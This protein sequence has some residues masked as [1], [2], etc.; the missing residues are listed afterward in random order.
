MRSLES[1]VNQVLLSDWGRRSYKEH[2]LQHQQVDEKGP[3]VPR[4]MEVRRQLRLGAIRRFR[5]ESTDLKDPYWPA[6]AFPTRPLR[7]D[8]IGLVAPAV[9]SDPT[10]FR[11]VIRF[12]R[13]AEVVAKG[14][15]GYLP[16]DEQ[17]PTVRFIAPGRPRGRLRFAVTSW[18]TSDAQW[19]AAASGK[20]DRSVTRYVAFNGMINRI[21]KEQNRPDY[22]VMSELS[23]PLRWALRAARKLAD[24]GV[25]ML[26]GIE[27]HRD[28]STGKLRNDCLVSLTT[29][30]PGYAS[31][32]VVLQPKFE[33]AHGERKQ[34][35]KLLGKAGTLYK[36]RCEKAKPTIYGHRGFYFSLLICSDLTNI[37]HRNSLRGEIDALFVLEWNQ[38]IKTFAALVESTANDLHAFIVQANNRKFGDSRIRAPAIQDYARDMVQVKG[39]VSDYYVMGEIDYQKLRAEQRRKVKKRQFKPLPIGYV[40]SSTRKQTGSVK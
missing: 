28:R 1:L 20:Q 37:L 39:G 29:H 26:A 30:W 11:S 13:G 38:D 12:L 25:S 15:I 17:S 31:S 4:E 36:P 34:L 5:P 27:Y 23:I 7:I 8:E 19:A 22:I 35:K 9:L 33:P 40:M 3:K 24:N 6:L 32:V 21:L 16:H 18:E 14:P 2:W 10:L